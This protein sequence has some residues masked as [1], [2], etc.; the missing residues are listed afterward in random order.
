MQELLRQREQLFAALVDHSP[1]IISRLDRA[2]RH[3]CT[4]ARP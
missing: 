4:R 3:I 1:D 2:L